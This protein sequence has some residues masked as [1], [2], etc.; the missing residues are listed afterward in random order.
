MPFPNSDLL[1]EASKLLSDGPFLVRPEGIKIRSTNETKR[2]IAAEVAQI[3]R[4]PFNRKKVHASQ[5]KEQIR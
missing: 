2:P 3:G 4:R 1:F 5:S